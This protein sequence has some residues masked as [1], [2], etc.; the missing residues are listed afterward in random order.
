MSPE[1]RHA[2]LVYHR[3]LQLLRATFIAARTRNPEL[4]R[5]YRQ[6]SAERARKLRAVTTWTR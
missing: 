4:R 3:E 6:W 2:A 5:R 1:N